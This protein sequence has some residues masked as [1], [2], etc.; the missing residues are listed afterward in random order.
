[1]DFWKA[2]KEVMSIVQ[3]LIADHHPHL[4]LI[5]KDIT[6]VFKDKATEKCG[7]IIPGNT[8]KAPPLMRVLTDKKFDYKFIIE[9]GADAWNELDDKQRVAL[10]DHHMCAMKVEEDEK[11]G[12]VKC[13]IRP[14][15]F[16]GYK[17]EVERHGMWRPMDDETLSI[18]EDMFGKKADEH[19]AEVR[20][21]VADEDGLSGVLEALNDNEEGDDDDDAA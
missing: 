1:M 3:K 2:G 19:S 12:G 17:E 15:D 10:L 16:V 7:L 13:S 11:G 9:L 5:E 21:R 4:A 20:K 6:V 18:I 8:K 14:P